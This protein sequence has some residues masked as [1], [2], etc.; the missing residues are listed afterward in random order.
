MFQF[1]QSFM[2]QEMGGS[3]FSILRRHYVRSAGS[4]VL[5]WEEN[6]PAYGTIHPAS[7]SDLMLFPEEY[8]TQTVIHLHTAV[9]V[10]LGKHLDESHYTAPDLILFQGQR[11]LA[12]SVRDWSA[13]GFCRAFAVLQRGEET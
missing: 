2:D 12:F 1:I 5:E 8:R 13:F 3:P 7:A 4:P 11:F 9:P 10:S 6:I